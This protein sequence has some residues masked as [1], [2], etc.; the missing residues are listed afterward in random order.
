MSVFDSWLGKERPHAGGAA[1]E[2]QNQNHNRICTMYLLA[3]GTLEHN[4]GSHGPQV[5][6]HGPRGSSSSSSESHQDLP[7]HASHPRRWLPGSV[8]SP[9]IQ[10]PLCSQ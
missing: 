2:N 6:K 3:A 1:K 9:N 4:S 7:N 10:S 8:L 5:E